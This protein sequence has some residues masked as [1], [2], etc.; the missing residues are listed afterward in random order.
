MRQGTAGWRFAAVEH[1]DLWFHGLALIG[2]SGDGTLPL[3]DPEY[4]AHITSTKRAAGAWPT[5]LDERAGTLREALAADPGFELLHFLPL[6]FA[7]GD[8]TGVLRAVREVAGGADP[9]SLP[10]PLRFG[11]GT[12]SAVLPAPG[13]RAL[14]LEYAQLLE[15][16]WD[17]FYGE[18][19]ARAMGE[20]RAA[21]Q[22][23]QAT[24]DAELGPLLDDYLAREHLD[25]G[26][27]LIT[28][29]LALEGRIFEGSPE[30]RADNLIAV[31]YPL[32]AEKPEAVLAHTVRELCF[33]PVR[34]AREA[35]AGT[36]DAAILERI[37]SNGAVRCGLL[38]LQRLAPQRVAGYVQEF[39][40]SDSTTPGDLEAAYPLPG[41]M[42]EAIERELA[43]GS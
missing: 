42:I 39:T 1:V 12:L 15:Q 19:H 17:S 31:G 43:P 24:W 7:A 35:A 26:I 41:A 25:A 30:N 4:G 28:P 18:F 13:Q 34:R 22:A 37:S 3:Y 9:G 6:Y 32:A 29:A 2:L 8:R 10:A 33:P 20:R 16:E 21:H 23:L 27:V 36:G 11:A 5:A 14:A 38:L 40:Q